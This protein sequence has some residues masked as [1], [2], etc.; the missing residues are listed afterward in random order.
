MQAEDRK[1]GNIGLP[2]QAFLESHEEELGT[3]GACCIF[4]IPA[5]MGLTPP[6]KGLTRD[7]NMKYVNE[8]SRDSTALYLKTPHNHRGVRGS[9]LHS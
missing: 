8:E 6:L 4:T 7:Q 2:Y 9:T 1:E 5:G 3:S